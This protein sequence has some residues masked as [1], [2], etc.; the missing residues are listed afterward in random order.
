MSKDETLKHIFEISI[1]RERQRKVYI[2][3]KFLTHG[4]CFKKSLSV[5]LTVHDVT[6]LLQV[7]HV[8]SQKIYKFS[9]DTTP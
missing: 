4:S 5:L 3:T 9:G 1:L 2:Q 7:T 6:M 8:I